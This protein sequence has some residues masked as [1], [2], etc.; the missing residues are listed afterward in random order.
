[1]GH[2]IWRAVSAL[3]SFSFRIM[4]RKSITC[5]GRFGAPIS[6]GCC[7]SP[8]NISQVS[9]PHSQQPATCTRNLSHI[10]P[11][12]ILPFYFLTIQFNTM[13]HS[14]PV[15]SQWP[16]S[17]RFPHQNP[18]CISLLCHVY[19]IPCPS[20]PSSFDC[21]KSMVKGKAI[22]LKAWTGTEGS[23]RLRVTDFK[24]VSKWRW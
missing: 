9:L 14:M 21:L 19:C 24:T 6:A 16:L 12:L 11:V 10:N 4:Q 3:R 13:L 15:F 22:P 20:H 17:F 23:R 1:M 7:L 8:F 5:T 2:V 18:V